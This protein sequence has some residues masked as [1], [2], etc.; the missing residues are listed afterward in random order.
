MEAT[1]LIASSPLLIIT[2]KICRRTIAIDAIWLT[3]C[4]S[5]SRTMSLSS[6]LL[7]TSPSRRLWS[8]LS[9]QRV[10]W[11]FPVGFSS[12]RTHNYQTKSQASW[13]Y[14]RTRGGWNSLYWQGH[15]TGRWRLQENK[16]K[17]LNDWLGF[18]YTRTCVEHVSIEECSRTDHVIDYISVPI[19]DQRLNR[20]NKIKR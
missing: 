9:M 15:H 4:C 5:L 10:I 14:I 3:L 16:T 19:R 13:A 11:V 1:Q 2:L 6:R 12:V 20:L 18:I 7:W 8:P 17:L